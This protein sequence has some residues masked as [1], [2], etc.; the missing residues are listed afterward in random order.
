[1]P[2]SEGSGKFTRDAALGL[3]LALA[4]VSQVWVAAAASAQ[5]GFTVNLGFVSPKGKLAYAVAASLSAVGVPAQPV[6]FSWPTA[7]A[8]VFYQ[9]SLNYS[10]GGYDAFLYSQAMPPAVNP[11]GPTYSVNVSSVNAALDQYELTGNVSYLSLVEGE[12]ASNYY[13][14]PLFYADPLWAVSP[15]LRGLNPTL[16]AYYPQPWDWSGMTN[17]T[18]VSYGPAPNTVLPLFGSSGLPAYAVF[19]PL[20]IPT[21]SGYAPCLAVNWSRANAT[22]WYVQL[23]KGVDFQDGVPM[24]ADDVVWSVKAALDPLTGSEVAPLYEQVLGSSV[25]FVLSNGSTYYVGSAPFKGVVRAV[26]DYEVE[27]R[28]P[29]PSSL[30]YPLFMSNVFVYPM[31]LFAKIGDFGLAT[32]SFSRGYSSVG[33]GPYEIVSVKKG[34]YELRAFT[35]YWNGTAAVTELTVVYTSSPAADVL[36]ALQQGKVQVMSFDFWPYDL[37]GENTSTVRWE[38]GSPDIYVGV[39]INLNSPFWGTGAS[40]PSSRINPLG[41]S[42]YAKDL[43]EAMLVSIPRQY[44]VDSVFGGLA[45]VASWPITP[46]QAAYYGLTLP[47]PEPFNQTLAASLMSSAGYNVSISQIPF[48]VSSTSL[49]QGSPLTVFGYLLYEGHPLQGATLTLMAGKPFKQVAKAVTGPSGMFNVTLTPP[50]GTYYV[51]LTYPGNET[52]LGLVPPLSSV[53]A[54]PIKVTNFWVSNAIYLAALAVLLVLIAVILWHR[55]KARGGEIPRARETAPQE[56]IVQIFLHMTRGPEF[57][58]AHGPSRN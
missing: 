4:L 58:P 57:R 56:D 54:G 55:L 50:S 34:E 6:R 47:E 46:V 18:Y 15:A 41:K 16:S 33:T 37:H 9:S 31:S 13:E 35:G 51:Q 5:P 3:L 29:E 36:S 42:E 52:A 28:L 2:L 12:L 43:R 14:L 25:E 19:Q 8:R 32:S 23:R 40:L 38:V 10:L 53:E 48:A 20:V 21:S 27:F 11:L 17:V 30:F 22:T 39:L 7:Y 45:Q 49:Q 24:T 26:G 44:L 1:M